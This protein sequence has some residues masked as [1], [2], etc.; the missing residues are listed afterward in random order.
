MHRETVKHIGRI[1]SRFE[2]LAVQGL[3]IVAVSIVF[4]GILVRYLPIGSAAMTWTEEA[5][6]LV[7]VWLG[8]LG[9]GVVHRMNAHYRL[10]F[11]IQRLSPTARFATGIVSN[12]LIIAVMGIIL[13][14]TI[15][16]CQQDISLVTLNLQWPLIL[17][18]IPLAVGSGLVILYSIAKMILK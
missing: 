10:T 7:L 17:I 6:R 8:F 18:D 3:Q 11:F 12:V 1:A 15:D 2:V 9:L 5:G 13:K 14:S 4:V 16:L